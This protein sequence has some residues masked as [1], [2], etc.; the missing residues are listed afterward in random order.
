AAMENNAAN[1]PIFYA[2]AMQTIDLCSV[3]ACFPH[4]MTYPEPGTGPTFT[5]KPDT[6]SINSSST[7]CTLTI[8]VKVADVGGPTTSSL[9]ESVGAYSL[10][11]ALQEG[12]EN[13]VAAESDTVPLEI[14]GVCCFNFRRKQAEPAGG[15]CERYRGEGGKS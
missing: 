7:P 6:G 10:A 3:S 9:L 14:D 12:A 2:G 5:G 1:Q 4:V 11:A 15:G 13:N 8:S